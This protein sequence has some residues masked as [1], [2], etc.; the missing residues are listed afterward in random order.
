MAKCPRCG[1]ILNITRIDKGSSG[2]LGPNMSVIGE[3]SS[4]SDKDYS[5]C[6]C[7]DC[8]ELVRISK[9]PLEKKKFG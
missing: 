3:R 7:H 2:D 8:G 9:L 6:L 4:K 1:A 5:L